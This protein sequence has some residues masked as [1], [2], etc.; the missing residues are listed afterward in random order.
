MTMHFDRNMLPLLGVTWRYFPTKH[1]A[2]AFA[3]WAEHETAQDE[4]PC[5]AFVTIEDD[6]PTDERYCVMVRNW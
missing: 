2:L 4:Y 3:Q 6:R 5:E 1:D